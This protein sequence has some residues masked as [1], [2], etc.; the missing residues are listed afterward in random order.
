M[1]TV[2]TF[3][4]PQ[5]AH[6]AYSILRDAGIDAAIRDDRTI[7]MNWL[8]SHAIGGVKIDVP[9]EDYEDALELLKPVNPPEDGYEWRSSTG[10]GPS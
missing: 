5:D 4:M 2:A 7:Q 8:W 1:Q 10:N 6:I 3:L 9:D